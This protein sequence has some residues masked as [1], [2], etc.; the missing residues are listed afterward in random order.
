MLS[1]ISKFKQ[2][3]QALCYNWLVYCLWP[4]SERSDDQPICAAQELVLVDGVRV[5]DGHNALVSVFFE[6][7]PGLFQPLKIQHTLDVH[8]H[9]LA[10]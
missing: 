1:E 2:N 7:K 5:S 6:I 9:L 4:V 10:W 3:F 8:A